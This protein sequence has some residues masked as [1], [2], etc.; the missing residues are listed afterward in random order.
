MHNFY[1]LSQGNNMAGADIPA[2][3]NSADGFTVLIS[4][5]YME[6]RDALNFQETGESSSHQN[7]EPEQTPTI[8]NFERFIPS[9]FPGLICLHLHCHFQFQI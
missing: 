1:F 8:S 7:P 9:F 5:K 2:G 3:S 6:A 4:E